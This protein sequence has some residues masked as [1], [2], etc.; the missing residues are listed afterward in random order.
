MLVLESQAH[1][2]RFVL[3]RDDL[4]DSFLGHVLMNTSL[5]LTKLTSEETIRSNHTLL[6]AGSQF[7]ICQKKEWT[8]CVSD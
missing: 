2:K 4:E 7:K 8:I 6:D 5:F 1:Q 3:F